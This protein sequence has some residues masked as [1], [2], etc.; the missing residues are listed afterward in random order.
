MAPGDMDGLPNMRGRLRSDAVTP[1]RRPPC[2]AYCREVPHSMPERVSLHPVC[3]R[4]NSSP[5]TLGELRVRASCMAS[6][7]QPS[8]SR[9]DLCCLSGRQHYLRKQTLQYAT[10]DSSRHFG[11][12][13]PRR[14]GHSLAVYPSRTAKLGAAIALALVGPA[15]GQRCPSPA[16]ESQ[17]WHMRSCGQSGSL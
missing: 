4:A 15:R 16:P 14:D 2:S 6:G 13:R 5:G 10:F 12:H 3:M 9:T 1:R 17:A 11:D 8:Y 7:R